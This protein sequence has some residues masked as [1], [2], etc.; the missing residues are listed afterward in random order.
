MESAFLHGIRGREQTHRYVHSQ[1]I[2]ILEV[3]SQ[4]GPAVKSAAGL[5]R[6]NF[7]SLAFL[8]KYL[9]LA[10]AFRRQSDPFLL[11]LLLICP[12]SGSEHVDLNSSP[13][14]RLLFYEHLD[15]QRVRVDCQSV[16]LDFGSLEIGQNSALADDTPQRCVSRRHYP[17]MLACLNLWQCAPRR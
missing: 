16:C 10:A 5:V 2:G 8:R 1:E 4:E 13:T 3:E 7:R 11:I 14:A 9:C 17:Y 6:A 15:H 12:Q